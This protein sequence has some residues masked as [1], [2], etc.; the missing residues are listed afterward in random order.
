M[1]VFLFPTLPQIES[2]SE[3][4]KVEYHHAHRLLFCKRGINVGYHIYV[5]ANHGRDEEGPL[6]QA[7][8]EKASKV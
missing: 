2:D 1:V 7:R 3:L 8:A 5:E 4:N 6:L